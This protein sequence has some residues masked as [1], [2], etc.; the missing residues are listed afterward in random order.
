[1]T[2]P[3]RNS[4]CANCGTMAVTHGTGG[5]AAATS[6]RWGVGSPVCCIS[7]E[8]HVSEEDLYKDETHSDLD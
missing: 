2:R 7:T 5:M 4:E 1:M 3:G 8:T 6:R